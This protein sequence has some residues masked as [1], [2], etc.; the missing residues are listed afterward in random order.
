LSE[1]RVTTVSDTA[2]TGPVTLT[3]QSAPK[4]WVS[5]TTDS[6]TSI[7]GSFN[8]SSLTDV[9]T[10]YTGISFTNNMSN[11]NYSVAGV[12]GLAAHRMRVDILGGSSANPQAAQF[13][14]YV[15]DNGGTN[16]DA[17]ANTGV[18]TGDLA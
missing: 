13:Y 15:S 5:Y 12:A 14:F 4:A 16:R 11:D 7:S 3:K 18:V 6:S 10:G 9:D 17:T 1:I 2:G 8:I